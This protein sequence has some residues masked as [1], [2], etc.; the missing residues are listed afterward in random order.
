MRGLVPMLKQAETLLAAFRPRHPTPPNSRETAFEA[1]YKG[2]YRR[3]GRKRIQ[4][5]LVERLLNHCQLDERDAPH[6]DP[7]HLV[8]THLDLEPVESYPEH[9]NAVGHQQIARRSTCG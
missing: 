4:H 9:P 1:N 8:P 6:H 2:R 3:W 7:L 5:R